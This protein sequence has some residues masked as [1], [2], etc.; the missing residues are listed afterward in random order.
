MTMVLGFVAAGVVVMLVALLARWVWVR[1][2]RQQAPACVSEQEARENAAP[3]TTVIIS[4]S[5]DRER[6]G[7]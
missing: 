3:L 7:L 5:R 1:W 6:N 4:G 2:R